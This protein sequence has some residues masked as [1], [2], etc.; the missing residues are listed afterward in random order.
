MFVHSAGLIIYD[1]LAGTG[2]ASEPGFMC[3]ACIR[4]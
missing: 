1:M 2:A 4:Y 3:P